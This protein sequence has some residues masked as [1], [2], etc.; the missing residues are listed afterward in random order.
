M[1]KSYRGHFGTAW[2]SDLSTT[3]DGTAIEIE[4]SEM[5]AHAREIGSNILVLRRRTSSRAEEHR[6]A[7]ISDPASLDISRQI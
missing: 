3:F 5:I 4:V 1:F 6:G 7:S 2:Q